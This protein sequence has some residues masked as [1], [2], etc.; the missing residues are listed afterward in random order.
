MWGGV[1]FSLVIFLKGTSP[2]LPPK[3]PSEPSKEAKRAG[4]EDAEQRAL[5]GF[6]RE[7]NW[8]KESQHKAQST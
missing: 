8:P 5:V 2:P 1:G 3:R 6:W 4:D 7:N